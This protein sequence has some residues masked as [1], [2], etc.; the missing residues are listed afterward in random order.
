MALRD[1]VDQFHNKNCFTNTSTTK[2][3]NFSSFLVRSEEINNLIPTHQ[4]F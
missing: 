4:K 2:E 1:V 3:A